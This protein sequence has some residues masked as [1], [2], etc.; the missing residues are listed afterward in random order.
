MYELMCAVTSFKLNLEM[1]IAQ[2]KE[3]NLIPIL[4][5]NEA[6]AGALESDKREIFVALVQQLQEKFSSHFGDFVNI[7][8]AGAF[9][10]DPYT[11][12]ILK[13]K[14]LAATFKVPK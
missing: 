10:W 13:L 8:S 9:L 3:G 7:E 1:Y 5:L 12:P 4:I 14:D 6:C 11:F 2:I